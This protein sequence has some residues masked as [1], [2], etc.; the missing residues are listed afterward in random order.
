MVVK[1]NL[2]FQIRTLLKESYEEWERRLEEFQI[3]R[4][5]LILELQRKLEEERKG[6]EKEQKQVIESIKIQLREIGESYKAP[7]KPTKK[8]SAFGLGWG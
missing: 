7:G 1:D 5:R 6:L 8:R 3:K 2:N 4:E